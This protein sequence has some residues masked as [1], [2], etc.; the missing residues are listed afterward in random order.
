MD[1]L[2]I[3]EPFRVRAT[4]PNETAARFRQS[5]SNERA[6]ALNGSYL[7]TLNY[8]EALINAASCSTCAFFDSGEC[9][10]QPPHLVVVNGQQEPAWPPVRF[11]S[12]CGSWRQA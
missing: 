2:E 4:C 9:R 10:A 1:A 12:W 3:A 7:E 5:L 8:A 11:D 6:A